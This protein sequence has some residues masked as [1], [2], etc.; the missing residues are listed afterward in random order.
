VLNASGFGRKHEALQNS[1]NHFCLFLGRRENMTHTNKDASSSEHFSLPFF[2][3]KLS[4][5]R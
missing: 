5:Y 4:R 2:F 1:E 3:H